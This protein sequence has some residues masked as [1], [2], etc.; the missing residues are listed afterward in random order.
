MNRSFLSSH[1][2]KSILFSLLFVFISSTLYAQSKEE[3]QKLHD[4]GYKYLSAGNLEE[5]QKYTL[6]AMEMR[7][8]LLGE[9]SDEYIASLNNFALSLTMQ[10]NYNKAIELQKRILE[11]CKKR[12]KPH[13]DLAMYT[14]NLGRSYYLSGDTINAIALWEEA[15][16]LAEKYSKTYEKVLNYLSTV[17]TQTNNRNGITRI[18]ALADDFNQYKLQQEC[19]EPTCMFERA[20][21]YAMSGE[22]ALAKDCYLKLLAMPMDKKMKLQVYESYAQFLFN[23]N[24]LVGASE[25]YIAIA[26]LLGEENEINSNN[27]LQIYKAAIYYY[28]G[29]QYQKA[30][31]LYQKV[32]DFYTQQDTPQDQKRA[33]DC[34]YDMGNAYSAL[35]DY[36]S[37][38]N[39][40]VQ[41]VEYYRD[42]D[43][44]NDKYP[45]AIQHLATAEKNNKNYESAIEY[46][47][48]AMQLFDE[49]GMTEEYNYTANSLKLC[50]IYAGKD[51]SVDTKSD[52]AQSSRE[53]KLDRIIEEE[54][55]N[56]NLYRDYL[57]T[58]A[59]A[60]SLSG[61]AGCYLLKADYKSATD[62]YLL[63]MKA[64]REAIRDEFR[65]QSESERMVLWKEEQTYIDSMKELLSA[66][67]SDA[68][69]VNR[70]GALFYDLELL[71]KGILLKSAIEFENLLENKGD[72]SLKEIYAQTKSNEQTIEQLRKGAST[73]TD[74]D[75]ILDLTQKNQSLILKLYKECVEFADFTDYISY[76]W[77]D[78]QDKM[79]Q[80]DVAIEFAEIKTG[81]F[82]RDNSMIALVL[83]KDLAEPIV[84]PICNLE[85]VN[86]MKTDS[87]LF[88]P[89]R[90]LVWG[91]LSP[92]LQ[93][94]QRIFFSA[95]GG[96]N[97][98][99]IEYLSY[100]GR[101]L[102]EQFEVYRLSSTKELCTRHS[103]SALNTAA[104]FGN[105][106][107][108]DQPSASTYSDHRGSGELDIFADLT[109]TEREVNSISQILKA[110][111]VKQVSIYTDTVASKSTFRNLSNTDIN[112]IHIATHGVYKEEKGI[113][114]TESME[115]SQLAFAGA[116]LGN[117]GIVTAAEVASMNLRKCDLVVLS[118]CETGL[119]KLGSDG[120]FGLQRGFKNAGVNTLLM[121][122]K[123]VYDD[124]T[125]DLMNYFYQN[126][127]TGTSKR[128]SLI[129]AQQELRAHGYDDPR[130]WAVFILLDAF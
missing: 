99:G 35:K 117:E 107:Y 33:A 38:R 103:P 23:I 89:E 91:I 43:S 17:Y 54:K 112:L 5:G 74:I 95:D 98:I 85:E 40:Y 71:S 48:Q 109:H 60:H 69:Q 102:S 50:Y 39:C 52:A 123:P 19:N 49:R 92:Y 72:N 94:K 47:K 61:I 121:S 116:N 27:A 21:Y 87:R 10:D 67:I 2:M 100:N 106:N 55:A 14:A 120:V 20:Q 63:Y 127:A 24:D 7:K 29:A 42:K 126:M 58:L 104:L 45:K 97:Q 34:Y 13:P 77:K 124:S 80:T 3:A 4:L 93:K 15:L 90:N 119:G 68:T 73:Q 75:K 31:D 125:A 115:N 57:G 22:S 16:P 64:I 105:I 70:L 25:Y 113:S 84:V 9:E 44:H 114:D 118:A 129:K 101:P 86:A 1:R 11:L 12:N 37:A 66:P 53:A 32:L 108:N 6:Q 76:N 41:T 26:N 28:L 110:H 111:H 128:E 59:Y 79:K 56:L 82:D 78:V 46:Y 83:T 65:L 81:I 18:W 88:D 30:I 62:Y 96:F 36:T 8:Q 130:Y 122:L 51:E